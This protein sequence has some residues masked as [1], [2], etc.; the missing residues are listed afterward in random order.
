M[1]SKITY[2]N[3]EYEFEENAKLDAALIHAAMH[4]MF[5]Q[6]A[7]QAGLQPSE[8]FARAEWMKAQSEAYIKK[9]VK[10][11]EAAHAH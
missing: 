1:S 5:V 2:G 7:M 9:V 11:V 3:T 4:G 10:L 6:A 8:A